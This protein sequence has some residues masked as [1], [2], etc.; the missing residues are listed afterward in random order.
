MTDAH[1]LTQA[2]G[3]NWHGDYGVAPCP[4]CQPEKRRDQRGLSLCNRADGSGLLAN[5]HKSA[6]DFRDILAAIRLTPSTFAT[7][8]PGATTSRKAGERAHAAKRGEHAMRLWQDCPPISE[9]V[10]ADYLRR[11]CITCSLPETLRFAP[12]CWHPSARRL[13]AMMA[14]VEGGEGFAVHRTYLRADGSGKA[15]VEPAKAMLGSTK[16]G[17]TRLF[18]GP[19]PLVVAEGI[20]TALSLASGL[21]PA[22]AAFWAALSASGMR[23]LRLPAEPGRLIIAPDCDDK[24]AGMAAALALAARADALGWQ[25]SLLIPQNGFDW[26]DVVKENA[27]TA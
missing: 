17:A 25:V 2:L 7:P 16:G 3:G 26:N 11:R 23:G 22:P 6:C 21:L 27:V 20:E 14:L 1:T 19:G 12:S 24:G 13:P 9:T 18:G 8:D 15:E 10:A 4:I 5:C